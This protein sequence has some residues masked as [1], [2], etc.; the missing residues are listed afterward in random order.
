VTAVKR[1]LIIRTINSM[2]TITVRPHQTM[3]DV[4]I[5]ATGS[6]EAAVQFCWDNGVSISDTPAVGT[7][8]IVSDAALA[9]GDAE[10]RSY[11]AANEVELGTL[12]DA[13]PADPCPAPEVEAITGTD[14]V[15]VG[16]AIVLTDVTAGGEWSGSDDSIA[17]VAV[18]GGGADCEV[19]GVA[20]GVMTVRYKVT[21]E[22]GE[23]TVVTKV[24]TVTV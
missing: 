8:Y 2:T 6:L 24:V 21:A 11:Y 12:A 3:Q 15:I 19:T 22:C 9:A 14:T 13:M 23:F 20:P 7:V 18:T 1:F 16:A 10:V 17:T 4:I 5:V